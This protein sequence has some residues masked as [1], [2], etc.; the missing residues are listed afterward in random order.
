MRVVSIPAIVGHAQ[1]P[2]GLRN[3]RWLGEPLGGGPVYMYLEPA[4]PGPR[5]LRYTLAKAR[6]VRRIRNAARVPPH[7]FEFWSLICDV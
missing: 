3:G 1:A 7:T 2:F 4:R 6:G 5:T